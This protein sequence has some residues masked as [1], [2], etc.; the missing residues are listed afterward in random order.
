MRIVRLSEFDDNSTIM[1][2]MVIVGAGPVG[3]TIAEHCCR[4]GR[5]VILVESGLETENPEHSALNEVENV[6]EL[7]QEAQIRKRVE[8]H[9]SQAK[10]WSPDVQPFGVRCRA[11]GGSTHAWAGKSAPFDA[12]DFQAR[13]WVPHSGWPVDRE[14]IVPYLHRAMKVLNLSPK[15][16]PECFDTG[17]LRSFYWQFARSRVDRLDVMRFG[18]EFLGRQPADIDVLLDATVRN[19]GLNSD[20]S[21]FSHI[22]VVSIGGK[23]ARIEAEI[24]VLAAGGI[25]NARLLLASTEVL[26]KGVGNHNDVVGRYL[27]DHVEARVGRFPTDQMAR[28]TK[29]FGFYGVHHEKR[30]HMFAHGLALTDGAQEREQVLNAAVFFS[31]ERAPDD[32]WVALKKLLRSRSDDIGRDILSVAAGSGFIAR[33][34]GMKILSDRRTPKVFKDLVV[35]AAIALSPNLVADEFQSQGLPRKLTG[36][37]MEAICEQAPNP[38]SRISLSDRKDKF[39]VPIAKIDWR[40]GDLERKTLLRTAELSHQALAQA[41]LATPSLESWVTERRTQD[42]VIID[43]AHT[44]GTTRMSTN[45]R[46]GV[47]D[48][49]CKV[50]GINNLYVA[51]GSVF[52]TSGHANPTLMILSLAIR[53]A[54]HLNLELARG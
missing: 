31:T 51:G 9:G 19:I 43:M 15:A 22:D 6:G 53:L 10:F 2:D 14:H 54:D 35:N 13:S 39:G 12:L 32:P 34:I 52:P 1:A 48:V 21:R 28:L 46:T 4:Q 47:V 11:L 41:G 20:V 27:M 40:I 36:L 17:G 42:L 29:L 38:A 23:H 50:H 49:N 3:L 8:F 18:P 5:R 45:P 33:G 16:P 25:E 30:A 37:R 7:Q 26:S 44:L 24:C